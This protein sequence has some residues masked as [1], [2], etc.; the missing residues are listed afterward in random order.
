MLPRTAKSCLRSMLHC[1]AVAAS[2]NFR[3]SYFDSATTSLCMAKA[4]ALLANSAPALLLRKRVGMLLQ[5]KFAK[6]EDPSAYFLSF[7]YSA[8]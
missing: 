3:G 7:F 4:R 2:T 1:C 5:K 6:I 8:S